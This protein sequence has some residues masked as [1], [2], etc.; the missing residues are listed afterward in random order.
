MLEEGIPDRDRVDHV[1]SLLGQLLNGSFPLVS[2][3]SYNV[4]LRGR[5]DR[6][7]S[8]D[9]RDVVAF[10]FVGHVHGRERHI[11]EGARP[12]PPFPSACALTLYVSRPVP[13]MRSG[14]VGQHTRSGDRVRGP[15]GHALSLFK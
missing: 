9:G 14:D 8:Q 2:L 15:R 1:G 11:E 4:R 3:L 10:Q 13:P 7:G 12:T 5:R 6:A